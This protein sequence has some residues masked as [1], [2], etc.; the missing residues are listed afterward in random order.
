MTVPPAQD[1]PEAD[2]L[3]GVPAAAH[4]VRDIRRNPDTARSVG[5]VGPAGSGKS[6]TVR[7]IASAW[8]VNGIEVHLGCPPD[9]E[10]L[11]G[12][13]ALVVDDAHRLDDAA[14]ER[15]R[16]HAAVPGARV[17]VARRPW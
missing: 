3:A 1:V 16:R 6:V 13:V 9:G 7:E 10:A 15:V 17:V 4:L 14:V 12:G 11:P 5:I 8:Q 2:A